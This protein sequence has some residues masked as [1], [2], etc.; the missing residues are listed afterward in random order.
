MNAIETVGAILFVIL[1]GITWGV[2]WFI[3]DAW[4][5]LINAKRKLIEAQTEKTIKEAKSIEK[6]SGLENRNHAYLSPFHFMQMLEK[7]YGQ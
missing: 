5:H 1:L 3:L 6:K 2:V 7:K 4:F